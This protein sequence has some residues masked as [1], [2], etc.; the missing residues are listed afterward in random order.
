MKHSVI[1]VLAFLVATACGLG[2]APVASGTVASA[3]AALLWYLAA[4]SAAAQGFICLVTIALG[5]WASSRHAANLSDDDPS[6]VVIDEV[7]GMWLTLWAAPKTIPVVVAG[8]L[9]F[10]LLDIGK[11]P[12]MRQ[13]ERLP[14]GL[15]I[16]MDDLAAGVI[17][18]LVLGIV[19]AYFAP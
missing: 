15:G 13:L 3:A 12:P 19:L 4:P 16:M 2:R 18:R 6:E 7:A 11:F 5:L 8:F 1:N 9:L 17:G 14:G 10:R